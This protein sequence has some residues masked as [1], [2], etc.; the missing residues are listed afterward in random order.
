MRGTP[1]PFVVNGLT[2][3]IDLQTVNSWSQRIALSVVIVTAIVLVYATLYRWGMRTFEGEPVTFLQSVQKVVESVTTAG[4]GGH[5]PWESAEM[6]FIVLAMNLTGVVLVFL[7]IP[8]FAIPLMRQILETSPPTSTDLTDHVIVCSYSPQDEVLRREL[9]DADVPYC[10]VDPDAD[11]V[12]D[13]ADDDVAA[14][15]GNPEK[16]DALRA[17]NAGQ[18]RAL[19][20]DVDDRTNPTVTISAERVDDDLTTVSVVQDRDAVPVHR[21]AGADDVVQGK[22]M[23]GESLAIRAS[24]SLSERFRD[25]VDLETDVEVTEILVEEDSGL[26]GRTLGEAEILDDLGVTVIGGWF[27]G[28][29]VISPPPGTTIDA[30]SILLV[31]GEYDD[32]AELRARPLPTGHGQPSR[33]VVFG[34]GTVGRTVTEMLR[35]EGIDVDVVDLES[36]DGVDVVGDVTN[37]RTLSEVDIGEAESVVLALDDD[38]EA[39]YASIMIKRLTPEVEIVARANDAENVWKLYNAGADYVLSLP[40]VTGEILASIL[41]EDEEI[42]SPQ[43]EFEFVRVDGSAIPGQSLGEVDLRSR[44]GC[45]VVAVERDGRLL[46]DVGASFTVADDDVLV[47]AGS[48]DATDQ[49]LELLAP[50]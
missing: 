28:K 4:F 25:A 26:A 44:T 20:A 37:P 2:R 24:T 34:Y 31:A 47:V 16:I 6:N 12:R 49:C 8:A 46:T 7:A 38:A 19:V 10:V 35:D 17:A 42:L 41:V 13:L 40:T 11:T 32:L 14:V 29:F 23:L 15:H 3:R 39:I 36:G 45:T 43:R 18:A 33:V 30:N 5:A 1:R 50:A 48:T 27:G 9:D 21:F 22:R